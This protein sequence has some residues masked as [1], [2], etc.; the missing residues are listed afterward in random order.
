MIQL[1]DLRDDDARRLFLWRRAPEVD[2]WMHGR[3]A[4]TFDAHMAW[5]D[6]F[7]EDHDS[8]GWIVAWN[9]RPVGF[10]MLKG[11]GCDDGRADWGWYIGE[12]RARG[13]GVGR[14]AQALA[15]DEAFGALGV[16]KVTSEVLV[17]NSAALKVQTAAGFRR[18]GLLRAHVLKD[19]EARDVVLL[20]LLEQDWAARREGYLQGLTREIAIAA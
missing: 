5:F 12:D 8:K 18:E 17:G 13:R 4:E 3:P 15:L 19:D 10:V 16:R 7:R 14:A 11:C 2:R 1:R 6:A 9:R 20:G